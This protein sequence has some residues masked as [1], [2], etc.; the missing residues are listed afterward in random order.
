MD[1]ILDYNNF[2]PGDSFD[3]E[4]ENTSLKKLE[5]HRGTVFPWYSHFGYKFAKVFSLYEELFDEQEQ[6]NFFRQEIAKV[7]CNGKS[8][9][10]VILKRIGDFAK[11]KRKQYSKYWKIMV[12]LEAQGIPRRMNYEELV[13]E[14]KSWTI[15]TMFKVSAFYVAVP[16]ALDYFFSNI[17]PK[18]ETDITIKEFVG[19]P[20]LYISPGSAGENITVNGGQ[21][22]SKAAVFVYSGYDKILDMMNSYTNLIG[23][24]E[25]KVYARPVKRYPLSI[26]RVF[27]K[28]DEKGEKERIVINGDI[29]HYLIMSYLSNYFDKLLFPQWNTTYLA[30]TNKLVERRQEWVRTLL[31]GLNQPLDQSKFDHHVDK[32]TLKCILDW[33]YSLAR[34]LN[35]P[36]DVLKG[37]KCMYLYLDNIAVLVNEDGKSE[38]WNYNN[39]LLSGWRWTAFL[40]TLVNMVEHF[41]ANRK[42]GEILNWNLCCFQGDDAKLKFKEGTNLRKIYEYNNVLVVDLDLDIHPLKNLLARDYDEFLRVGFE[43]K[44]VFGFPGRMLS[45]ILWGKNETTQTTISSIVDNWLKLFRRMGIERYD[46]LGT[47]ALNVFMSRYGNMPEVKKLGGSMIL[48]SFL[49]SSTIIGGCGIEFFEDKKNEYVFAEILDHSEYIDKILYRWPDPYLRASIYKIQESVIL[50]GL[51]PGIIKYKL[52]IYHKPNKSKLG[53]FYDRKETQ[54]VCLSLPKVTFKKTL[55][56]FFYKPMIFKMQP[57]DFT[58]GY[59]WVK[60]IEEVCSRTLAIAVLF[61]ELKYT[62][63]TLMWTPDEIAYVASKYYAAALMQSIVGYKSPTNIETFSILM[64][65]FQNQI[66]TEL[67]TFYHVL[68]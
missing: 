50:G 38:Q 12:G 40:G 48:K 27:Q 67:H 24:E 26:C 39:G 42:V 49:G 14:A 54:K 53:M 19:R 57:D 31:H 55:S 59:S 15:K 2:I 66:L 22:R 6:K 35:A 13:S 68:V 62:F 11:K 5:R 58:Q 43:D 18:S 21:L 52:K 17:V 7:R 32:E 1:L 51:Y 10:I 44:T 23:D 41:Y 64:D 63:Q 65:N 47:D 61:N 25:S 46:L 20:E 3:N 60:Y 37:L 9:L 16:Q 45:S 34:K 33:L 36:V 28:M 30:G 8:S 4:Q 56:R 29:P